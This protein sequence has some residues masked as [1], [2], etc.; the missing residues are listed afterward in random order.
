MPAHE[1]TAI[2]LSRIERARK[3]APPT[4]AR[5]SAPPC[6]AAK[7]RQLK[8]GDFYPRSRASKSTA[9]KVPMPSLRL[10]GRWLN[11]AG[12]TIGRDVRVEVSEGRL[13]IELVDEGSG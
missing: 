4:A 6:P 3:S 12:F 5:V 7:P 13:T 8:V 9:P 11:D 1:P 2:P 10:C